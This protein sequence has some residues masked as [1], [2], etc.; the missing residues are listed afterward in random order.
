MLTNIAALGAAG[1]GTLFSLGQG[2][3]DGSRAGLTRHPGGEPTV[4]R[5][6]RRARTRYFPLSAPPSFPSGRRFTNWLNP[7]RT[8]NKITATRKGIGPDIPDLERN[9]L[10]FLSKSGRSTLEFGSDPGSPSVAN[11]GILFD[12]TIYPDYCQKTGPVN[13][14]PL[15]LPRTPSSTVRQPRARRARPRRRPASQR[16]PAA[17]ADSRGRCPGACAP[18]AH[19]PPARRRPG[20]RRS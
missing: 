10:V 16:C 6:R 4:I 13:G 12:E 15:I 14:Q 11:H 18:G 19:A 2:A 20:P 7:N 17:W 3:E 9:A 8:A 1:P 5:L